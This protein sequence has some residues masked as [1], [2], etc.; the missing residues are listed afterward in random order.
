MLAPPVLATGNHLLAQHAWARRRLA[1][2][3]GSVAQINLTDVALRFSI[4]ADGYLA[5]ATADDESNV[6]IDIPGAALAALPHGMDALMGHVKIRGDA[7]FADSLSFVARHLRWDREADLARLL[8][9][10]AG[11]RAHLVIAHATTVLPDLGQRAA[12]NASEYLVHEG[13]V[14]ISHA[15]ITHF[16]DAIRHL[17][18]D[19][20]RLEKRINR[21]QSRGNG[22]A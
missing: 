16:G 17:R 5:S 4:S 1:G 18:D 8:G 15:E 13:G 14:L 7:D 22:T 10:I 21:L 3:T 12:R 19:M 11:R 9:P 20:A 2:H 6:S